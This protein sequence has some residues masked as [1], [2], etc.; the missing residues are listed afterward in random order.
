MQEMQENSGLIPGSRR[1]PGGGNGNPF[2]YSG[3]ENSMDRGTWRATVHWVTKSQTWLSDWVCTQYQT[4]PSYFQIVTKKW[5]TLTFKKLLPFWFLHDSSWVW[6]LSVTACIFT[7]IDYSLPPPQGMY[8]ALVHLLFLWWDFDNPPIK[9]Q[10][11]YSFLLNP[12]NLTSRQKQH[13]EF[14]G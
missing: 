8:Y 11:L 3:L 2:Q 7:K 5:K 10:G 6:L 1:S 12:R 14:Q 4:R 9:R 13:Y